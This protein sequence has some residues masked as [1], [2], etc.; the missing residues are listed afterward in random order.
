MKKLFTK[1]IFIGIGVVVAL[2]LGFVIYYSPE[3]RMSRQLDMGQKYLEEQNY[4]RA[5]VAFNEVIEIDP[6]SVDA[7]L[8]LKDAYVGIGDMESAICVL[9]NGIELTQDTRLIEALELLQSD[10]SI[11]NQYNSE[12][13]QRN[14]ELADIYYFETIDELATDILSQL[15]TVGDFNFV[16]ASYDEF[17]QYLIDNYNFSLSND[18][19]CLNGFINDNCDG[20]IYSSI[21]TDFDNKLQK[22]VNIDDGALSFSVNYCEDSICFTCFLNN[23]PI[24]DD[25]S[26]PLILNFPLLYQDWDDFFAKYVP[27]QSSKTDESLGY[28]N[29]H[30]PICLSRMYDDSAGK[31][32][33]H[34]DFNGNFVNFFR[35][36]E[37]DD[38]HI[39]INTTGK[40]MNGANEIY[41]TFCEYIDCRWITINFEYG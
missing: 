25:Y 13:V 31:A 32:W 17:T 20:P 39:V 29:E 11:V 2:L 34:E 16:G 9:E 28:G 4:E 18:V 8:G 19:S 37:L 12:N 26:E 15:G 30:D 38:Y 7:Y 21:F 24:S 27:W 23:E 36:D 22:T 10:V 5:K 35:L 14:D 3:K 41:M 6:I 33:S 40:Y 1:R